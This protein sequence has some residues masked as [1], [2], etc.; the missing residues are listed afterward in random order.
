MKGVLNHPCTLIGW[1]FPCYFFVCNAMLH[2]CFA[3][4]IYVTIIGQ[5][6]HKWKLKW[7]IGE[8]LDGVSW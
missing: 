3:C 5:I 1:I 6:G 2:F 8:K 7:L 4:E